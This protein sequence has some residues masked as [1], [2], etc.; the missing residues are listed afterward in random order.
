M[1]DLFASQAQWSLP[2]EGAERLR[3]EAPPGW[4]VHLVGDPTVA[5][6][7]GSRA[8]SAEAMRA[9]PDAEAYVGYGLPPELLAAGKRLRWVHSAAAGVAS[10]LFPEMLE[11]EVVLTN[12]AGVHAVPIAE[13]VIGGVLYLLRQFDVAVEL[14]RHAVWYREPFVGGGSLMRELGECRALIVGTGGIGGEVAT[15]L[16]ALGARCVG[17]RRRPELGSPAGFERVL[18]PDAIEA[19]AGDCDLLIVAAPATSSTRSLVTAR[20]LDRLPR[21][22]IVVNVARGSLL[23]EEALADRIERGDLRGAVL[24]VFTEEPLPPQSRLWRLPSVLLTP[25]VSGV[26]PRGFWRRELDL[27][28]D[29]WR[30]Y[31]AGE[32]LRNVVDKG[33]GY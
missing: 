7:D 25:H 15:R 24:D 33:A 13:Y 3:R 19:A 32:P 23:D 9:I 12:S 27:L 2:P 5:D 16:A 17:V 30:R 26:S 8:A 11:S 31:V 20:L 6:G 14:Q 1:V 28:L 22:A 29:N 18:A 4:H 10:L 21:G